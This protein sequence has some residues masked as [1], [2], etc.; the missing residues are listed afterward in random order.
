MRWAVVAVILLAAGAMTTPPAEACINDRETPGREREFRSDYG[1][2]EPYRAQPV[3][4][5]PGLMAG[6]SHSTM[7]GLGA[8]LLTSAGFLA[9]RT[10][11]RG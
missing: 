7:T 4:Q 1:D 11:S 8:V 6:L 3:P 9:V 5:P 10:R 2:P